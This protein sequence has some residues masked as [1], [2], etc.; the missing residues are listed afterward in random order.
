MSGTPEVVRRLRGELSQEKFAARVGLTQRIISRL[1]DGSAKLTLEHAVQISDACGISL[2][3]LA[4]RKSAELDLSGDWWAA[5][6]TV[7]DGIPRV[8]IHE[9]EVKQEGAFFQFFGD[10][11]RSV[12]D[13]SYA[14]LGEMRMWDSEVLMGW[15]RAT[16]GA[17]RSKGTMF[18]SLHP[19]G[20]HMKGG[21]IGLSYQA[22]VVR[23]WAA[24]ARDRDQLE[25]IME[26]IARSGGRDW[27][28]WENNS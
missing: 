20:T 26:D 1:E 15:Y 11:A 14:W 25:A 6:Q 5:W 22:P 23:G 4:G 27:L 28:T 16:D 13:G 24:I 19:H 7:K 9:L 18:M 17:V 21:W 10:R 8:D 2:T 12:E 3:E